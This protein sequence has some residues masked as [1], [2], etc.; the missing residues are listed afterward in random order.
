MNTGVFACGCG[1]TCDLDLE[2]VREGVR[3]VE[4]VASSQLL[5]RDGLES[6]ARVA[7]EYDLDQFLVTASADGCKDRIREVADGCGLHPDAVEFVDHREGAAWV[8]DGPEAT[9][10][11][12]R[13]LNARRAGLDAEA[14]TRTVSREAGNRVLVVGDPEAAST[15]GDTADVVLLADGEDLTGVDGLGDLTIERGRVVAVD[16]S[17]G[18]FEVTV[19]ARVTDD[20]IDCM[21]CV[22]EGPEGSVTARPVDVD[23]DAP[24]G[25]WVEVCPTDAIDLDGVTRTL[26]A[27]QVVYPGGD[28]DTRGGRLGYYTGLVD[29]ATVA[30]VESLLGGVEKPQFLDLE[31]DVCAA[32]DSS[33]QGCT[34]CTDACPHGAI[35]RPTIDS[36]AFDEVACQNCGA[37]TSACPTGATML[38]EPSNERLAREVE[39]LLDVDDSGGWLPWSG[40]SGIETDVVA[41]VCSERAADRLRE[42]GRRARRGEGSA[43]GYPPVLP[44]SVNCTDTVGEAHV[45]HALAAGA[46][47]V[48]IV[49]CGD[50]CLHSGPDP[51]AALVE[52]CNRATADLGLGER[53]AFLSPGDDPG[54][55]AAEL[56]SFVD[57][58][59][60]SPVPAGEHV[61]TGRIDGPAGD[62]DRGST[63]TVADGGRP[64]PAFDN[65][66]WAL[67]SVR[68]IVGHAEPERDVIRG[69]SDFGRVS[70]SDACNFTPTCSNLCPTDA[71][72]RTDDGDLQFDHERCV[73][74]GLCAEGCPETAITV[75]DGL[76]LS[77]LPERRG[78]D[79]WTTVY[80]GEMLECARCGKPFTS[81]ATAEKVESEVGHLVEGVAPDAEGSVFEYCGD[82]RARLLFGGGGS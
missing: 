58:L 36:V 66:G 52:R 69:L 44:V 48:A 54:R 18:G 2:G 17:F 57:G 27:D 75:H 29:G 40:S 15:L 7:E 26:E 49:G 4:V 34:A 8:H 14:V 55:F 39:A 13:M 21:E 43:E 50:A 3:D 22:R 76:D 19:E 11:V 72:R 32:G 41:F 60:D 37:C 46:D 59:D 35:D 80:E 20:C 38:R 45:L 65:H 73:N 61:A 12:A 68:A 62:G 77:L 78:G 56:G 6:M 70:V 9:D 5:C 1:G 67:E 53:V 71:L 24:G 79:P 16:G 81:V 64:N 82:C 42:Y 51:K 25:D 31:M 30:A 63:R 28:P 74:C 33:Q 10:K 23:P 47:G